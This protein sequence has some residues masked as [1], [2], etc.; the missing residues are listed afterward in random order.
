MIITAIGLL[1]V[2]QNAVKVYTWLNITM[3]VYT[4]AG[5]ALWLIPGHIGIS[6]GAASGVGNLGIAAVVFFVV[7]FIYPISSV[8]LVNLAQYK[9]KRPELLSDVNQGSLQQ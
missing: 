5:G 9:L 8:L 2:K 1:R 7:P 4:F 3:V 6:I